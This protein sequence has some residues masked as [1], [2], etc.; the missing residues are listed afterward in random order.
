MRW[1]NK[2]FFGFLD[3]KYE[4]AVNFGPGFN[5]L[6]FTCVNHRNNRK[7]EGICVCGGSFVIICI[8]LGENLRKWKLK[9]RKCF[10]FCL[11]IILV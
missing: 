4:E 7:N 9:F 2:S 11:G 1:I 10:N 8:A 5:F 6:I 3:G